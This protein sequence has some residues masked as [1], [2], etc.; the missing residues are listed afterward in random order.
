[1]TCYQGTYTLFGVTGKTA[2][3]P[4]IHIVKRELIGSMGNILNDE[5]KRKLNDSDIKCGIIELPC[6]TNNTKNITI[7]IEEVHPPWRNDHNEEIELE[8][9]VSCERKELHERVN[10]LTGQT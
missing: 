3:Y 5:G 6:A 2:I 7:T 4:M 9:R 8:K 1:M 10:Y